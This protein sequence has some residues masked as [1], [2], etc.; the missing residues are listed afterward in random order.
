MNDEEREILD[1]YAKFIDL[2]SSY[3][4]GIFMSSQ[5]GLLPVT[6]LSFAVLL[7]QMT[8]CYFSRIKYNFKGTFF[9]PVVNAV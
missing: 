7:P 3:I 9:L 1:L 2:N 4:S 6:Y 8:F 5:V